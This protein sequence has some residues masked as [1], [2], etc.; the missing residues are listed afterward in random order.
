MLY[1]LRNQLVPALAAFLVNNLSRSLA[2]LQRLPLSLPAREGRVKARRRSRAQ[3][4]QITPDT[5]RIE[6][7]SGTQSKEE[8]EK[9]V[10][11]T[12]LHEPD[13]EPVADIIFVHGL[14]GGK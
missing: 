11:C 10:S 14:H 2:P 3:M 7:C 13:E 5:E 1:S 6:D 12:V 9:C 4:N 8:T